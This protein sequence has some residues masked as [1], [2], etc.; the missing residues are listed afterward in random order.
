MI[1]IPKTIDEA[2]N[3]AAEM[4]PPAFELVVTIERFGYSVKLIDLAT[5]EIDCDG[6][7]GIRSDII[8]G[9]E[10]AIE[11]AKRQGGDL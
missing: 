6:G 10:K 3:M 2:I 11:A 1:Q 7:D 5:K 4:L 9:I 8:D